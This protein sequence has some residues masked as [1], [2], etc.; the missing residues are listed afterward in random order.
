MKNYTIALFGEAERGEF[1][2]AYFLWSL[3]QLVESLGNPPPD[4]NGLHCAVQ[5]LMYHYNLLYF[6][7]KQEGFS[8]AD[9]FSGLSLLESQDL[10][11][12]I[13]AICLPG[14]GDDKIINAMTPFCQIH[15]SILIAREADLYDYLTS[16]Q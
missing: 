6:R 9:Y 4:S 13:T 16:H 5:A 1:S 15:H 12:N 14:V 10:I 3:S 2:R 7:V 8:T 11:S